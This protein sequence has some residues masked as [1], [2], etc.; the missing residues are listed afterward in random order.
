[1]RV[2]G[3]HSVKLV[4]AINIRKPV[5]LD[6][7]LEHGDGRGDRLGSGPFQPCKNRICQL[8]VRRVA[9]YMEDEDARI[10]AYFAVPLEKRSQF[11][12]C[13]DSLSVFR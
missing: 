12:Y 4:H 7:E 13:Q 11:F 9:L 2:A 5:R 3:Q 10:E 8:A 6:Q 1:M